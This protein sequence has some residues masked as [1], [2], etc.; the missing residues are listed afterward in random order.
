VAVNLKKVHRLVK[1]LR[2]QVKQRLVAPRPRV[3]QKV[4]RTERSDERWAMELS[5]RA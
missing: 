5:C 4:S 3:Q 1:I 2:L